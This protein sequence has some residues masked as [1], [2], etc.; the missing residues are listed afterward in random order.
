M[1]RPC[2]KGSGNERLEHRL[3]PLLPWWAIALLGALGLVLVAA[4]ALARTRGALLR[5]LSLA[6]LLA[7]LANPTSATRS[8]S[9]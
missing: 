4:L 2:S 1:C 7:A 6:I 5:A 8:A 3:R 9:R